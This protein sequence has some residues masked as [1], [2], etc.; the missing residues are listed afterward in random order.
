[1]YKE[2]YLKYKTKYLDLKSQIGSGIDD[3][4][5]TDG[6]TNPVI[7]LTSDGAP[8]TAVAL[9]SD[10]PKN[11]KFNMMSQVRST[12]EGYI[13]YDNPNH[14]RKHPLFGG[15]YYKINSES[16][17]DAYTK[18]NSLD[19]SSK[20]QF[21]SIYKKLAPS[22][23]K[24]II[25]FFVHINNYNEAIKF[26][27]DLKIPILQEILVEFN[28][29]QNKTNNEN[30]IEN[31]IYFLYYSSAE[32]NELPYQDVESKTLDDI[33]L[34][35]AEFIGKK[36]NKQAR[37]FFI[38]LKPLIKTNIL[39][40][41]ADFPSHSKRLYQ[42]VLVIPSDLFD[43][44]KKS[45][46]TPLIRLNIGTDITDKTLIAQTI[47]IIKSMIEATRTQNGNNTIKI[48]YIGLTDK[49]KEDIKNELY[50]YSM[51]LNHLYFTKSKELLTLIKTID[52]GDED[53]YGP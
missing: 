23:L 26:V 3:P 45:Y 22:D 43:L 40:R 12:L 4:P 29:K 13:Y 19:N 25:Y 39:H 7:P 48:I 53:I 34:T 16:F 42:Y 5:T 10:N 27:I 6:A 44:I 1:M 50:K 36:Q 24:N 35:L 11:P 21:N 41:I 14:I 20:E 33:M 46:N 30:L 37:D 9:T 38:S 51:N 32:Y 17:D 31:Y 8:T 47:N 18:Y 28:S 15:L 52:D 49:K 2:K